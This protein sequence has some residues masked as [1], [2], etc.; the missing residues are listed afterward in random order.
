MKVNVPNQSTGKRYIHDLS[1][2][3]NTTSDFGFCQP[4]LCREVEGNSNIHLRTAQLVRMMPMVFPTFGRITLNTY[5]VFVPIESVY[6]PYG[7]LRAGQTYQGAINSYI[8]DMVISGSCALLSVILKCLSKICIYNVGVNSTGGTNFFR[9]PSSDLTVEPFD[10]LMYNNVLDFWRNKLSN[11]V[12]GSPNQIPNS[13]FNYQNSYNSLVFTGDTPD[14][15]LLNLNRYDWYDRVT[16]SGKDYLICGEYHIAAKNIR[17]IL[18]GCGYKVLWDNE[19]ISYL[20]LL[21]YYKAWFDL[22]NPQRDITWKDTNAAGIQ[23]W[24][25]QSGMFDLLNSSSGLLSA[26][27]D[28]LFEFF[29]DLAQCYYTS[30]PDFVSVAITGQNISIVPDD[31]R[32]YLNGNNSNNSVQ[33]FTNESPMISHQGTN[34]AQLRGSIESNITQNGLNLLRAMYYRRNSHR[35]IGGDIDEF[36]KSMLGTE[37]KDEDDSYWIGS[38]RL[39]VNITPVFSNSD[40]VNGQQG[41]N[42]GQFAGQGSGAHSGNHGPEEFKY[43]AKYDGFVISMIALVPES[44]YSQGI[45]MNLKHVRKVDFF[46]P[47]YDSYSLLPTSKKYIFAESQ[48]DDLESPADYTASFGNHPIYIEKCVAQNI[49]NGDMSLKSTRETYLPFTLDKLLPFTEV[50]EYNDTIGNVTQIDNLD[51][52]VL[53]NSSIWRYVGLFQWIGNYGRIYVN[54]GTVTPEV[55]HLQEEYNNIFYSR[56]YDDNNVVDNYV[57]LKV[58]SYKLPVADSF[59]TGTLDGRDTMSIEIA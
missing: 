53:V 40:T 17:K 10:G 57:Y 51:P 49:L 26:R 8:P 6:H 24:C 31:G 36:M 11:F 33:A 18:Y 52:N 30:S 48:F 39:D 46:D 50:R 38:Q 1:H 2:D 55:A 44:R 25:E 37:Y 41:A 23:E 59:Q 35:V 16:Y 56:G 28:Q 5:N 7:S 19:L 54:S 22:F 15:D 13:W 34:A 29:I 14:P 12:F 42:L 43:T 9:F 47:L 21:A 4:I 3:V 27:P 58:S 45:D 32:D 20:P